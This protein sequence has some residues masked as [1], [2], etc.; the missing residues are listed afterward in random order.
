METLIDKKQ[1]SKPMLA[2]CNG[3]DSHSWATKME[4]EC[5]ISGKPGPKMEAA[6]SLDWLLKLHKFQALMLAQLKKRL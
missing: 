3:I 6:D 5:L 4:I 2:L 1:T